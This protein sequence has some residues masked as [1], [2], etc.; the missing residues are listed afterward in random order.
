MAQILIVDDE[1]NFRHVLK[2]ILEFAG[3]EVLE[4]NSG[5]QA[6]EVYSSFRAEL[7]MTD[8]NMPG[9]D[10]IEIIMELRRD[11]PEVKIIA[12]SGGDIGNSRIEMAE[13]LGA[14]RILDKPFYTREIL[15][16][17]ELLLKKVNSA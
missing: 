3:H 1:E 4:A 7:V 2:E 9:K 10:G 14:D 5:A 16:A 8:I 6:L 12:M 11:Y 17:V 15:D 13:N